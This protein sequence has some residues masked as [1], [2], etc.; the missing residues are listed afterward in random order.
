MGQAT[1]HYPSLNARSV[2]L[3]VWRRPEIVVTV[4]IS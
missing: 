2:I 4:M 3:N 1:V